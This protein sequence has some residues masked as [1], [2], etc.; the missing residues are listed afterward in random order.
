M[1]DLGIFKYE[2]VQIDEA[3]RV[4]ERRADVDCYLAIHRCRQALDAGE[5]P[6]TLL[7]EAARCSSPN[8]WLEARRAKLLLRIG[9]ACERAQDW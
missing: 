8:P 5:M 9:Q 1:A 7:L 4:F 2:K 6:E 3:S